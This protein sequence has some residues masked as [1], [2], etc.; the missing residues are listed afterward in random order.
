MALIEFIWYSA[1]FFATGVWLLSRLM[2]EST[3]ELA[4]KAAAITLLIASISIGYLMSYEK[5]V[6]IDCRPP[7]S[8]IYN[9][10]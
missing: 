3:P 5:T 1:V 6:T 4:R 2:P 9:D 10:C 7:G 8:G